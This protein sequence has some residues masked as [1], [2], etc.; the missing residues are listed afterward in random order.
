MAGA[1][2]PGQSLGGWLTDTAYGSAEMLKRPVDD[3]KAEDKTI[4]PHIPVFD[5]S[6]RSG[7]TFSRAD[8]THDAQADRCTCPGGNELRQY[9]KA[10]R[11]AKAK[12]PADGLLRY[13]ARKAD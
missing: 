1:N 8:L 12:P 5:K 4:A 3:R 11:A 9:W 7:G 6:V 13:H 10:G 2:I